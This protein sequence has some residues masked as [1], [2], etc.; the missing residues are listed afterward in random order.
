MFARPVQRN[1]S[2]KVDPRKRNTEE[3]GGRTYY[4][5]GIF[6]GP[7]RGIR[8]A[9]N[10]AFTLASSGEELER[11]V[12]DYEKSSNLRRLSPAAKYT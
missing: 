10:S 1:R 2:R 12:E 3:K 5:N 8:A 11:L 7:V 4:E 9:F 6:L